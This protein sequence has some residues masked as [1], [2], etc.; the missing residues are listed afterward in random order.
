MRLPL[1]PQVW[2]GTCGSALER[3]CW[4][5][6]L[7]RRRLL[8]EWILTHLCI[9]ARSDALARFEPAALDNTGARWSGRD[10]YE[11]QPDARR[12][13]S[14]EMAFAAKAGLGVA[15]QECVDLG[16]RRIWAR[17]QQLAAA[18][19]AGL[20]GVPGVSLQ[21]RGA[22]LCGLVSFTVAGLT[23]ERRR[24]ARAG[25]A[26]QR[27]PCCMTARTNQIHIAALFLT[28][29][30]G[31]NHPCPACLPA[32]DEVQQALAARRINVSVSRTGSSRYDF[33][34]RGLAEVVRASVHV[35]LTEGQLQRCVDA[36]RQLAQA[37]AGAAVPA[38]A[39]A[40]S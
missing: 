13:E 38:A 18:L 34:Q 3:D 5:G 22:T 17:V 35:Y 25:P 9:A 16:I 23:G 20:A 32:A 27:S 33:E 30:R 15:V 1:L 14:Y 8:A 2:W 21:D 39:P 12:F 19:R 31:A 26:Q 4:L 29:P 7:L 11:L 24:D 28:S 10:T 40:G 36:V 37:A 6:L